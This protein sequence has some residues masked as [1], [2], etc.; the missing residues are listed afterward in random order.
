MSEFTVSAAATPKH[1]PAVRNDDPL[2]SMKKPVAK[3]TF[4]TRVS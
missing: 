2:V 4:P 3:R 1:A